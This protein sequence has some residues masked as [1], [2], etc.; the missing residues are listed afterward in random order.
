MSEEEEFRK[1]MSW[2][3]HESDK[4]WQPT[5]K[6]VD[7]AMR[8][9]SDQLRKEYSLEQLNKLCQ[10]C[11]IHC[12]GTFAGCAI[13][14]AIHKKDPDKEDIRNNEKYSHFMQEL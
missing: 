6:D 7:N 9:S 3:Q 5:L 11:D 12:G 1:R 10:A 2:P 13:G 14:D 4:D 8:K